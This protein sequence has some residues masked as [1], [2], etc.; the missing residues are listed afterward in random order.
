MAERCRLTELG[1][2][3]QPP[4]GVTCLAVA[5]DGQRLAAARSSGSVELWAVLPRRP[6]V[7]RTAASAAVRMHT[8]RGL[9]W[10]D[11][12]TVCSA[13]L[14]GQLLIYD[15]GELADNAGVTLAGAIQVPGGAVWDLAIHPQRRVLALG[16]GDGRVRFYSNDRVAQTDFV[17]GDAVSLQA[18]LTTGIKPGAPKV[19]ACAFSKDGQR[20]YYGDCKG[21]LT[22]SSWEQQKV[23]FTSDLTSRDRPASAT[24]GRPTPAFFGP[25]L[26]WRILPLDDVVLCAC[27]TGEVK[28]VDVHT[29]VLLQSLVTHKADVLCITEVSPAEV[30]CSGV[31]YTLVKLARRQGDKQWMV[32]DQRIWGGNDVTCA[33][34]LG[35]QRVLSGS[36]DGLIAVGET[37][38]LFGQDRTAATA[39]AQHKISWRP[40]CE[41]AALCTLGNEALVEAAGGRREVLVQLA[42][43]HLTFY[44]L[45]AGEGSGV[46]AL[47]RFKVAGMHGATMFAVAADASAFAFSTPERTAVCV[48]VPGG[49]EGTP[50]SAT[51]VLACDGLP[52]AMALCWAPAAGSPAERLLLCHRGGPALVDSAGV[53]EPLPEAPDGLQWRCCAARAEG[54]LVA[55]CGGGGGAARIAGAALCWGLPQQGAR[56]KRRRT[57]SAP[58][59]PASRELL[60]CRRDPVPAAS[61][62]FVTVSGAPAL[63][64]VDANAACR[65]IGLSGE[66][67]WDQGSRLQALGALPAPELRCAAAGGRHLLLWCGDWFALLD[68]EADYT[69]TAQR[70]LA[71]QLAGSAARAGVKQNGTRGAADPRGRRELTIVQDQLSG[72]LLRAD[73]DVLIVTSRAAQQAALARPAF[74]KKIYAT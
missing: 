40:P 44:G 26:V 31:D 43:F 11:A 49:D 74:A 61:A 37:K 1:F 65:V 64:T 23:H 67:V 21:A 57:D 39:K 72:A 55:A 20:L 63:A 71:A 22:A 10:L 59:A 47:L 53:Q 24:R 15:V 34:T 17:G 62:A 68:L 35:A 36:A 13:T 58:A 3:V 70:G 51:P 18:L 54:Q 9:C 66:L 8:I 7:K 32:S 50:L 33:V 6:H 38:R 16:C 14:G 73:G 60:F 46:E 42:P 12:R 45:P 5:P 41:T 30:Y 28:V 56:Q 19:T 52:P 48:L 4:V 29:G 69:G 27:A 25:A 2:A